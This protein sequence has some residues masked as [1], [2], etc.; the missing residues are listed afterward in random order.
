M[1]MVFIADGHL[2]GEGD[3]NQ[4]A[5]VKFLDS[6]RADT[7]AVM[8]DLFDFWTGSNTVARVQYRPVLDAFIRLRKRGTK[9]MYFE[10][11]HDFSMGPFFTVELK[12]KVFV[13]TSIIELGGKKFLLGHG[14]TV[15]MT[16][17]YRLWRAYLRSPIF[18]FLAAIVT[19][20][21]VWAIANRLS[22]K[23]RKRAQ[24]SKENFV[25]SK[26]R[27]YA[28]AEVGKGADFV[29]LGHS[30]EPGV[31]MLESGGRRG[32]YANPGSW[33]RDKSYL[34][35]DGKAFRVEIWRESGG[36]P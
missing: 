10:G 30:H 27:G 31:N 5:L 12:A 8:G 6:L 16:V 28:R 26:L 20:S 25:E 4:A 24:P 34:V 11:N 36:A 2:L 33:A 13:D 23:S 1:K 18:G 3:P 21:G 9:I 29:V 22:K 7:L 15:D 19:P 14:D 32:V 35:F 17:G